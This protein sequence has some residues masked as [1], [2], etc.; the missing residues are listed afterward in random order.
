MEKNGLNV[1]ELAQALGLPKAT[2]H[3][4]V[5]G[6]SARPRPKTLSAFSEYFKIPVAQLLN[7]EI[8]EYT[9]PNKIK[10][11]PI[12]DWDNILDWING[13]MKRDSIQ[14]TTPTN[15]QVDERAFA[16]IY[17]EANSTLFNHGSVLVFDPSLDAKDG[18]YALAKFSGYSDILLRQVICDASNAK[19][20][21]SLNQEFSSSIKKLNP[22]DRIIAVLLMSKT[23]YY[24]K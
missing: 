6:K 18:S 9:Q 23:L 20:I 24:F 15:L 16:L 5:T 11:V 10:N 3:K 19:Y 2:L 12:I 17:N 21:R 1:A 22:K 4:I 7:G 14:Q 13:K 8:D